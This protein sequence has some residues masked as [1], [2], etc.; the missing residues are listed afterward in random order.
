[1]SV[2]D[3]AADAGIDDDGAGG[4]EI[5]GAF[6]WGDGD[7]DTVVGVRIKEVFGETDGLFAE[8]E[9]VS[10]GRCDVVDGFFRSSGEVP[11]VRRC[12]LGGLVVGEGVMVGEVEARPIVQTCS[13]AGLFV[14]V[15]GEGMD[16]MERCARGDAGASDGSGVVGDLRIQEYDIGDWVGGGA[17]RMIHALMVWSL[18]TWIGVDDLLDDFF[19]ASHKGESLPADDAVGRD[20][21]SG[22]H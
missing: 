2:L 4:R 9:M 15:K 21:D 16:E 20:N 11:G 7:R 10:G 3:E 5:Q 17:S 8:D 12:W 18:D 14:D 13:S 6:D 19:E 1:M 22:G